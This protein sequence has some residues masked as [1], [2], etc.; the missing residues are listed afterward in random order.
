MQKTPSAHPL[1]ATPRAS[2]TKIS[3]VWAYNP[4]T[5]ISTREDVSIWWN[6]K[7]RTFD[8]ATRDWVCDEPGGP[9]HT[10]SEDGVHIPVTILTDGTALSG[11]V[12][13]GVR[14]WCRGIGPSR[15]PPGPSPI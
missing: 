10:S 2:V 7:E 5:P 9:L 15:E 12:T 11:L 4:Y 3:V 14:A 8:V 1:H 13:P 6:R